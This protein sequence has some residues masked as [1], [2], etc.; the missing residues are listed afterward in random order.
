MHCSVSVSFG[1]TDEN[2]TNIQSFSFDAKLSENF[3]AFVGSEQ[4]LEDSLTWN[5]SLCDEFVT[6]AAEM[7]CSYGSYHANDQIRKIIYIECIGDVITWESIKV[8]YNFNLFLPSTF[9]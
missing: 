1:L 2:V 4:N 3:A 5:S 8:S 9:S 7:Q 6:F